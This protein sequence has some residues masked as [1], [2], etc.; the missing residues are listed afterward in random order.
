MEDEGEEASYRRIWLLMKTA[1][2]G[3]EDLMSQNVKT[4]PL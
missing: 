3:S 4:K 2:L 1:V